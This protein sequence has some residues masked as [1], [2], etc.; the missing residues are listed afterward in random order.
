MRRESCVGLLAVAGETAMS[1]SRSRFAARAHLWLGAL[2]AIL[3]LVCGWHFT[4]FVTSTGEQL[5]RTRIQALA[6][7]AA[8]TLDPAS[9]LALH[10]GPADIGKGGFEGLRSTMKRIREENPGFRFVYLMR[11][12]PGAP[13]QMIFLADAEPADSED[14]SAPGDV[15]DGPSEVLSA[16]YRDG[17]PAVEDPAHDEWGYWVTGIAPVRDVRTGAVVA[18]LGMDVDAN[19]WLAALARYRAFALAITALVLSLVLLFT[20]GLH[21]QR[22][23]AARIEVI[24]DR[25]AEQL[26]ALERAQHGLLLADVVVRHTHEGIIVLDAELQVES[27]NPGFERITGFPAG[28][29]LGQSLQALES[30]EL[31]ADIVQHIRSSLVQADQWEGTLWGR[32]HDGSSYPLEASLDVVRDKAGVVQHHV[33][34]FR[35]VTVQKQLEDRLRQLSATDGLTL[36]ANRRAFDETL[37]RVWQ[38]AMRNNEP[39]SLIMADIDMFKPYNDI[40]GHLNGD[41]CLQQVAST[42]A[43]SVR[44][45]DALVA[46]YGGEEFAVILP[47]TDEACAREIAERIRD[48]VESLAIPHAGNPA[49]DHVTISMGTATLTP[50][51]TADFVSLMES[52]DSA[53]YRAKDAGRNTVAS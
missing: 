43:A 4:R 13:D 35:D 17:R 51:Q 24:N 25:L 44:R 50:P 10:G 12:A 7:T 20:L 47:G 40:Y 22:R 6:V 31:E 15:Y 37:E 45:D 52:A 48:R 11:P 32:R 42:I 39:V 21:L 2:L 30:Q 46:R 14:Y 41:H 36:V 28:E 1:N 23:A 34:V 8:S 53:L 19:S 3:V 16:A 49:A 27:V 33:V 18:V 9:V 5:E 29:V 38:R 26:D